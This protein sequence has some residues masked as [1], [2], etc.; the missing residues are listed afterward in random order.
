MLNAFSI[1]ESPINRG[2][3]VFIQG[4]TIRIR[5]ALSEYLCSPRIAWSSPRLN[6]C[7]LTTRHE[8]SCHLQERDLCAHVMYTTAD[9]ANINKAIFNW[10]LFCN[11]DDAV[12]AVLKSEQV[13]QLYCDT[14][15]AVHW[16]QEN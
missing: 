12:K 6:S 9:I 2:Y 7:E 13:C 8:D 10:N 16:R 14:C 3:A 4:R 1:T 15:L 5:L 11:A